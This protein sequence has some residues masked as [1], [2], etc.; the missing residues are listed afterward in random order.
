MS[1]TDP[2][3]AK[4]VAQRL[5]RV[6]VIEPNQTSARLLQEV[7]RD[8]G[9]RNLTVEPTD[10][11]ALATCRHITPQVIFTELTG[12]HVD[13]L[14]F[15]RELRR[16]TLP[17]RKAPVIIVTGEATAAAIVAARNAGVH[18]FLR[19]PFTTKDMQRRIEAVTLKPRDWIEA[20][21]YIGPDRR[22]FNS[23][24]YQGPRKRQTDAAPMSDAERIGQALKILRQAIAAIE[25]DPV[26]A[27]RSMQAQ[28][29]ILKTT[30]LSSAGLELASAVARLER[31]L[32]AAAQNGAL[33]RADIENAAASLWAFAP[34]D[35]AKPAA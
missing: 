1:I 5:D 20:I 12:P 32:S 27:L 4:L 7:L 13:G 11:H 34:P 6:L 30:A 9:A 28:A 25:S 23:G 33:S 3:V 14:E 18:E 35:Q 15:T 26:Q 29:A 8:F 16:S 10:E 19:K 2:R 24:D 31:Q 22:R 17:C 21:A